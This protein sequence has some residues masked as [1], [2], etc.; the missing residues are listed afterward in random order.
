MLF[1]SQFL[2]HLDEE[3]HMRTDFSKLAL[4]AAIMFAGLCIP[5]PAQ[6]VRSGLRDVAEGRDLEEV[7]VGRPL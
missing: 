2:I 3:T 5:L 7:V 1:R 4:L 6:K